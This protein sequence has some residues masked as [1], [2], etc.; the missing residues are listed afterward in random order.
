MSI[1]RVWDI[2]KFFKEECQLRG[3][4]TS[5]H[6]D[7]VSMNDQYHNFLWARTVHPSTFKKVVE[8]RKCAVRQGISYQIVD[9]SYM[10]WLFPETP[11]KELVRTV[12]RDPELSRRIAIY[13]LS[14]VYA[15]K[16]FC[17]KLNETDSKVFQEFEV[18]LEK[19]L[20]VEFKSAQ[21]LPT[22]EI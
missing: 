22:K 17:L 3:W 1:P 13:D 14:R 10:A 6:E 21:D 19:K 9:M 12:A 5:E 7:W 15:G 2:L 20:A 16:P 8:A 11:P 4:K 18:F